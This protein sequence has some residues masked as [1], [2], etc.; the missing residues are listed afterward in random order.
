MIVQRIRGLYSLLAVAQSFMLVALYWAWFGLS[1]LFLPQ[2]DVTFLEQYFLYCAILVVGVVLEAVTRSSASLSAPASD[3][4]LLK[5]FPV[6]LR[7][8][9]FA[10]GL[11]MLFLVVTKDLAISRI[12]LFSFTPLLGLMLL[13]TNTMVPLRLARLVFKGSREGRTVLVGSAARAKELNEWLERKSQIGFL[14]VGLLTNDPDTD[15]VR[16][17]LLG[18]PDS[19]GEV[20]DR[21]RATQII[22]LELPSGEDRAFVIDTALGRGVRLLILSDLED[23]LRHPITHFEDDGW[24]F[25][26][27]H[28]E[29]LENPFNRVLKRAI[30]L[31]VALPV[32]VFLLPPLALL[33]WLLQR[34]QSAGPLFYDQARAG[35]QNCEF[36]MMKFRTM[37]TGH[38]DEA[39]QATQNDER[40]FPAGRFLR[41]FSLDEIPQFLNVL[42]GEMSVVGP[43]PH[44]AEH[45]RQFAQAMASYHIRTFVKPGITGLAQ[46]RGFRGEAKTSRDIQERLQSDL[47]YLENWS[48]PLELGIILRTIWQM[49]FPPKSAF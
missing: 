31:A 37:H 12:F 46:V 29:P 21:E 24:N 5:Q 16:I 17:P 6:A 32:V 48:L 28:E 9:V 15:G 23:Q 47:V 36:K 42:R 11:V 45:N 1:V 43:R 20:L 40:V 13:L 7:Q 22:L 3:A 33:V 30:D 10:V 39:R 4:S 25:I 49:V 27:F 35:I 44:L 2:M 38:G 18:T 8:T 41:R 26:A 34:M 14:P 19:L